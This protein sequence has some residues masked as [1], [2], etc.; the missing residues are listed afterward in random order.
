[1]SAPVEAEKSPTTKN[2]LELIESP[3]LPDLTTPQRLNS[4][5]PDHTDEDVCSQC[6]GDGSDYDEYE[7]CDCMLEQHQQPIP[8]APGKRGVIPYKAVYDSQDDA[9]K[10]GYWIPGAGVVAKIVKAE[11]DSSSVHLFNQFVYTIA[12][13][14]GP[15]KWT[16]QKRYRDFT[17]LNN[18]LIAHRAAERIRAPAR[19]AKENIDEA[20]DE[21]FEHFGY[22]YIPDHK[23][24]C[25]YNRQASSHP[26]D[27]AHLEVLSRSAE[28]VDEVDVNTS[29]VSNGESSG[30]APRL[31]AGASPATRDAKAT[32][33]RDA[34]VSRDAEVPRDVKGPAEVKGSRDVK[35][36]PDG[37][38]SRDV[39]GP[40][41]V[42]G[43][44]DVKGPPD[45]EGLPDAKFPAMAVITEAGDDVVDGAVASKSTAGG[46]KNKRMKKHHHL[47]RFPYLPDSVISAGHV[48]ERKDKLEAWLQAVLHIPMNRNH[49]ETAEFLE[50]S[51]YSFVNQLGGKYHEGFVKKRPGGMRVFQGWRRFC[52]QHFARWGKRWLILKDSCVYYM[53][54]G[55]EVVHHVLFF[56]KEF[57][58]R[59]G[60]KEAEGMERGLMICN[61]QRNLLL[62]CES[63][64]EAERWRA[65]IDDVA[66]RGEGKIWLEPHRFGS[67]YPIRE[68]SYAQWFS[69][70]KYFMEQAAS[71]MELAREEIFIAD[72][73][74]S[75]EIYLK[76]PMTEGNRWRLDEILK[77]KAEQGVK[78]YIMLY[79]EM[80][81]ALGINSMY[82]K[83]T[84]Q[85]LHETN[86]KV[87]RHP[88]HLPGGTFFWAHHE[89]VIIIDQTI[90]YVGGIDLAYGRWDD[91]VHRL[92]DLGS[93]Q[94]NNVNPLAGEEK[95]M[96]SGM[97]AVAAASTSIQ[98]AVDDDFG[99]S[100]DVD[101]SPDKNKDKKKD[102]IKGESQGESK[103]EGKD[104][105][106]GVGEDEGKDEGKAE[107]K[108][109]RRDLPKEK[110][111]R[112][113]QFGRQKEINEKIP[114]K[115][116]TDN[117]VHDAEGKPVVAAVAPI[118]DGKAKKK[119]HFLDVASKVGAKG[120]RR[121]ST[122]SIE[123]TS[124]STSRKGDHKDE[125]GH[126][127]HESSKLKQFVKKKVMRSTSLD[128]PTEMLRDAGPP[129]RLL[130]TAVT[131][132][133]VGE[134]VE[135]YKAYV[136]SGRA[137]RE[138]REGG[139]PPPEEHK[140]NKLQR[141]I[142]QWKSSRAKRRWRQISRE[143]DA[144]AYGKEYE[145]GW[146]RLQEE[147]VDE[148]DMVGSGKIW[149]GKDYCNFVHKDFVDLDMP[150][151]DFID[152][153][154]TPRMPWHDICSVT[155]GAA[156]RDVARH[157]I[158]R[159]NAC[160]TEKVKHDDSYPFLVPKSY[161]NVKVPRVFRGLSQRC[162][163]QM[164]R[165]ASSWSVGM[166][167]TEDSI[168][169]A[170]LSMIANAK[171]YVYM[172][173]QF[174]VSMINS[175]DV[176]NEIC[177]V[178][179]DRIVRAHE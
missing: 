27:H 142:S 179:C 172:E 16:V 145:I 96:M 58:I 114:G 140:K 150:Y 157:F 4:H 37:K 170:Y 99:E 152:R 72:W 113:Q 168:Q 22:D 110:A 6:S 10:R 97:R 133:D 109:I 29:K 167:F 160:K 57:H 171:H 41:D 20:I 147:E 52:L 9:R 56:D 83:R 93:V 65:S 8:G 158:Q 138:K 161:D 3:G 85:N 69:D 75:P 21:T 174:F 130:S 90:A 163:V 100:D 166:N 112:A 81:M 175:N 67:T 39:K 87:L 19:R 101:G 33:A 80:E 137:E 134:A 165:S 48:N 146:L 119:T 15:F 141:A 54:P 116:A 78:I 155:Y 24:N 136:E 25:P 43:S 18:R 59:A 103:G 118:E 159:W 106:K 117:T 131:K 139:T 129:M 120:K 40:P 111:E 144:T 71:M 108:V 70:G 46:K 151:H 49:H 178:I 5:H 154:M 34:I 88:D 76:R 45:V 91:C 105:G 61:L 123:S 126:K 148:T 23:E 12:L 62:K 7:Y 164:L 124:P 42:K 94:L 143:D 79:K 64:E 149:L 104:A 55:D 35:G 44:P 1:M 47:P 30:L 77:R 121:T 50:V 128:P 98:L 95:T 32:T 31:A 14:H 17:H 11:R 156:A 122:D 125:H 92:I 102:K 162:N 73:W 169:Q 84:L 28:G 115:K 51:R 176:H 82:S 89:K 135:R 107:G 173:N 13:E 74:L 68:Q 127:L 177:K 153:A 38:G 132:M 60:G 53:D 2:D 63:R 26:H 36:P 66:R 86:V